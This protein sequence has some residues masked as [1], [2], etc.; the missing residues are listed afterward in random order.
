M[1][2]SKIQAL[3]DWPRF[4]TVTD[5]QYL[6]GLAN[7]YRRFILDFVRVSVPLS[8][9]TKKGVPFEWG[10][11]QENSFQN[12]KDALKAPQWGSWRILRNRTL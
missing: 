5:V 9:L 4:T 8:E 2:Q 6:L 1:Q 12:L 11:D 3:F 10:G 7:Y